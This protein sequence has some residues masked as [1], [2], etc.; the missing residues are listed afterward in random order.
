MRFSSINRV[1]QEEGLI[2]YNTCIIIE[3]AE[4]SKSVRGTRAGMA[5]R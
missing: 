3:E 1:N 2:M 4:N 5:G